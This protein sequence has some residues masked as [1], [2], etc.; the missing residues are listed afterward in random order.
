LELT[1]P[2]TVAF[3]SLSVLDS[4]PKLNQAAAVERLEDLEET[5]AD[6]KAVGLSP[7]ACDRWLFGSL[8]VVTAEFVFPTASV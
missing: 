5:K 7:R 4:A 1:R 3:T 6:L 8:A 2:R